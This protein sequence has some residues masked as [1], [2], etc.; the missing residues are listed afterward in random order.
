MY[1]SALHVIRDTHTHGRQIFVLCKKK[2]R[3]FRP[4]YTRLRGYYAAVV[5]FFVVVNVGMMMSER[6]FQA[7]PTKSL[8]FFPFSP[9]FTHMRKICWRDESIEF[10]L[11]RFHSGTQR[12]EAKKMFDDN[13]KINQWNAWFRIKIRWKT[14]VKRWFFE[15]KHFKLVIFEKEENI[16]KFFCQRWITFYKRSWSNRIFSS[17]CCVWLNSNIYHKI[18]LE[19]QRNE[20][21]C[22]THAMAVSILNWMCFSV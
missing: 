12:E 2:P 7:T 14:T 15:K 10:E 5:A 19:Q 3:Y 18:Q 22:A 16:F 6:Y 13:M 17:I 8:I 21:P 20:I 11:E 4:K 9:M 1:A